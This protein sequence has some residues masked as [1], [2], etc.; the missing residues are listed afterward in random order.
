M[1]RNVTFLVVKFL[2]IFTWRATI[3]NTIQHL[4]TYAILGG[5]YKEETLVTF[6][7][8]RKLCKSFLLYVI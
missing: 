4:K 2:S 5:V 1:T 3:E 7:K 8:Q 6:I